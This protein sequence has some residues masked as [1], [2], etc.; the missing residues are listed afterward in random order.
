MELYLRPYR[1]VWVLAADRTGGA[2]A[3]RAAR[4]PRAR[5]FRAEPPPAARAA[6]RPALPA[7]RGGVRPERL[8]FR[9]G[10]PAGNDSERG[11]PAARRMWPGSMW[12]RGPRVR[13]SL[14]GLR[15]SDRQAANAPGG[16]LA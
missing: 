10:G 4:G 6:G 14:S 12:N 16:P 13:P 5:V 9:G 7:F 1:R 15:E 11:P 8:R 3:I 2:G